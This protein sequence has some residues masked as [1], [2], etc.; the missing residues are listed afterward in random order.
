VVELVV[1]PA[2]DGPRWRHPARFVRLR[3][4]LHP[5]DLHPTGPDSAGPAGG[6][7]NTASATAGHDTPTP[8]CAHRRPTQQE[9]E[10]AAAAHRGVAR[11]RSR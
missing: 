11:R 6:G 8:T 3:P 9:H 2:T 7:P 10:A 1:D 4:D 5:T